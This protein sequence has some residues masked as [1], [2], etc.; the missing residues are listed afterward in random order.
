MNE[1][2]IEM[3]KT[4]RS[5]CKENRMKRGSETRKTP[6]SWLRF[7]C[8]LV[9]ILGKVL[10]FSSLFR[11][12]KWMSCRS[13]IGLVENQ[14]P[15][16][17]GLNCPSQQTCLPGGQ[18]GLS[19]NS[20]L[21]YWILRGAAWAEGLGDPFFCMKSAGAPEAGGR[22]GLQYRQSRDHLRWFLVCRA[23]TSATARISLRESVLGV[24]GFGS[25]APV[26]SSF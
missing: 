17:K 22:W 19:L 13:Q 7:M 9:G 16:V 15:G 1:G 2:I 24:S 12:R 6:K 25:Y 8:C 26:L 20:P 10:T 23:K 3:T 5:L 18:L 14:N 11:C 21:P 4:W